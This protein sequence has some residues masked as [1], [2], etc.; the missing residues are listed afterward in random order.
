MSFAYEVT[1]R[2]VHGR[3]RCHSGTFTNGGTDSGGTI[4]TGLEKVSRFL[5]SLSSH[6]GSEFPK[7]TINSPNNGDVTIVTSDGAD[8]GWVA[9]GD[10]N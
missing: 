6:L 3:T 9:Y 4:V 10:P 1:R 2:D 8:G 5:P 7:V